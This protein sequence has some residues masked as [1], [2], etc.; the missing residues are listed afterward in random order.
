MAIDVI[1]VCDYVG[2]SHVI[3]VVEVEGCGW[4]LERLS[5]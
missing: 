3:I 4:F 2:L 5:E 1:K